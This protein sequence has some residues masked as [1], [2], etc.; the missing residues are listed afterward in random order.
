MSE[1]GRPTL[2]KPENAEI[3]RRSC[4]AGATNQALAERFGVCRRTIDNWIATIPEFG[5]AV[6]AGREKA[7]QAVVAAL[8]QR[9]TG[10]QQQTRKTF[11]YRGAGVQVDHVVDHPPDTHACIFW[12]RNRLP[13]QWRENRRTADDDD[14]LDFSALEEASERVRRRDAGEI[15]VATPVKDDADALAADFARRLNVHR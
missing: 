4:M 1:L 15:T 6:L 12:L 10:F 2:Y 13:E 7:D 5:E 11:L 8:F 14:T 3:A 9:A